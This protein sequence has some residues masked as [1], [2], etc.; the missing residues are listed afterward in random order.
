[1]Q[2]RDLAR[3]EGVK[4]RRRFRLVEYLPAA[5]VAVQKQAYEF[6]TKAVCWHTNTYD[7]VLVNPLAVL[8]EE[9]V[10]ANM[11]SAA[12]AF[13]NEDVA[14][15]KPAARKLCGSYLEAFNAGQIQIAALHIADG[16][17]LLM[18]LARRTV[19]RLLNSS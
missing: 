7:M 8:V 19:R 2:C 1:F 12:V 11:V 6:G 4:P 17:K 5:R 15:L 9:R 14:T 13:D 18:K 3:A 16:E 10:A